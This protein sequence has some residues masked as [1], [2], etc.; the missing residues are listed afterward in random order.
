MS[1]NTAHEGYEYQDLLTAYFIL[2]EIL[3][4]HYAVFKIDTKEHSDDKFDD[5][6][7]TN[8]RIFKKQ[9][10]YS[11]EIS[12]HTTQKDD[13][14]NPHNY[15]LAIYDLFYSWKNLPS[16]PE[17][18]RLCLAW[19]E[20]T[21]KLT[22][23][24]IV[25]SKEKTFENYP[26]KLFQFDVNKLWPENNEPDNSWRKLRTESQNINRDEFVEFCSHLLIETN[27]P[28]QSFDKSFNGELEKII[29][30]LIDK[31]GI[32]EY[33]N[34][35]ITPKH[36]ALELLKLINRSRSRGFEISTEEIFDN[37]NILTDF[38]SI[39]QVFP[40]DKSK[41]IETKEI[42]TSFLEQIKNV[43]KIILKGE[44]GSG[45]SWFVQNL[46]NELSKQ[47]ISVVKHYCYTELRDIYA[48]K[49][50]TLNVF[51][52]NLINDIINTYPDLIN[53]KKK[54]YASNL[55]ELNELLRAIEEQ[56]IIIIDGLDHIER[57]F[58]SNQNDLTL[59]DVAIIDA[60]KKIEIND[61]TKILLV[62]QPINE[63][64]SLSDFHTVD[65][66]KW[67][68]K[69]IVEYLKKNEIE[70]IKLKENTLL[71]DFLLGKS[72]GNP[73]YL[74]YLIE[75]VKKIENINL[76]VLNKLPAYSYNLENYYE[77][78]IK[79]LNLD[80]TIPQ[81]LSG[82]QF[83][84][85][86]NELKEITGQGKLVDKSLI[87]LSPIL[88]QVYSNG[89]YII[90]HESFRR[91]IIEKL[92]KEEVNIIKAIYQPII[93]WFNKKDFFDFPK[94]YRYYF[95][96]LYE[97][98][99]FNE[100][101]SYLK[102]DF[103]IKSIYN[104][105][106]FEVIKNNFY[107]L[108]KAGLELKDFPK[109][110]LINEL[111]KVIISTEDEYFENF[112]LYF[113]ALGHLKG[114]KKISEYLVFDEKPTLPLHTGLE[115]CYLCSQNKEA[116]PW[117]IYLEYFE[118]NKEISIQDYKY[119]IRGLLVF[120]DSK[121]LIDNTIEVYE[122]Y[123]NYIFVFKK[124][125]L[126]YPDKDLINDLINQNNI[127]KKILN[128]KKEIT[129]NKDDL[130][131]LC[132]E[133]LKKENIFDD[134][135]PLLIDFFNLIEKNIEKNQLIEEVIKRFS[136]INWFYNW[137]I[138]YIK[139][140]LLS[141]NCSYLAVKEAFNY[142]IYDTEPFKNSHRTC[143][144]Y[145][146]KDFIYDSIKE[147]L[148]FV[149]TK[150]EWDEIINI[151]KKLSNETTTS[152]QKSINGPL[153]TDK[154]FQ[155]LDEYANEI[156]RE[157]IIQVFEE[158]ID[159]KETYY[160]HSYIT[161]FCFRLS[162][163]YSIYGD[164]NKAE[165]YF[166][167]GILFYLGYTFRKDRTLEDLIYAIESYSKLDYKKA[168]YDLKRI[169]SL[170]DA[171]VHHTD[172]KDT[173]WF[174][175][176]WFQKYLEINFDESSLYL[177]TQIKKRYY[178][179]YEEKLQDLLIKAN[180]KINPIVE[181]FIFLTFP[182]ETSEKFLLYGL[183]LVEKINNIDKSLAKI[184]FF[185]ITEKISLKK[186]QNFSEN[187]VEKFNKKLVEFNLKY[188]G[189]KT[190]KATQRNYNINRNRNRNRNRNLR[191]IL[192]EKY[193]SRKDFSEMNIQE[194]IEYFF[195]NKLNETE[196]IS[197]YYYFENINALIENDV[198]RLIETIVEKHEEYPKNRNIDLSLIFQKE[199]DISAYYWI[200]QFTTEQDGWFNKL[201]NIKAFEK[202][203]SINRELAINA[204]ATHLEKFLL[205]EGYNRGVSSN[206]INAFVK[207]GYHKETVIEMWNNLFEATGHRLPA[208]EVIN[209]EE[210][211]KDD[212]N[213]NIEEI[214]I[215]LL[216]TRFNSNTTE[217]HHWT[218]SGLYYLYEYFP[219]KMIKSTKWFLKN[220]KF[221][222]T[223]NLIIIL[224][225]LY[226]I[227]EQTYIQ[228]F[229]NELNEL[230]PSEYY[231]INYL[232]ESL[233][234]TN[235]PIVLKSNSLFFP[236]N[237]ESIDFFTG[238]NYRNELLNNIGFNFETIVG[239]N[240]NTFRKKYG[241][242]FEFLGNHSFEMYVKN[243]YSSN[244]VIELINK[245]LYK[246]LDDFPDKDSLYDLLKIDYKTIVSQTLSYAQ[247][248]N[249]IIRP[250]EIQNT[251][252]KL[253]IEENDWIRLGY[254]EYELYG[255]R[256]RKDEFRNYKIFEGIVFL[257]NLE[258]TIPFSRYRLFP[259]HLW[260]N[261]DINDFDEFLCVS[262]IQQ[263]DTLENFN[264]L[265]LN[266]FIM[267]ALNLKIGKPTEG[268]V[269]KYNKNEVV[270]KLNY[271]I[272][273]YVGDGELA[274]ITNEIPR[275][276]GVE[277]LCRKDYFNKI[278]EIY[279]PNESYRSY[280]YR[281]KI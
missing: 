128:Y 80:T 121:A 99:K 20:P 277:L 7:I 183:T 262:L 113:D 123:K 107:Y 16:K 253:E 278:C 170:V 256:F 78:L 202:A 245:E 200:T 204:L 71:S 97:I 265:W 172:G 90:Y 33:P 216:F 195:K 82:A 222:L 65:I 249:N 280:R 242:E 182:I 9:I 4:E 111:K 45:K 219:E 43:N 171:V 215:C 267:K 108:V 273:D 12:D 89:G 252:E 240:K 151:L 40:I 165:K 156:N 178:W 22:D 239:N 228:N 212:L 173:R 226:D 166:E 225:I 79:K 149:K 141:P 93:N 266:P 42:I 88:K 62:S 229:Y 57:I 145:S 281:L 217:R 122:N 157:K 83:S 32:G 116:A 67:S 218:L 25:S 73:L 230:Y 185:T 223:S 28:K 102:K 243:I 98:G 193:K 100:I 27:F 132:D 261:I 161:E 52:A 81:I 234:D 194:M 69:E 92:E 184:V 155:L 221:F 119:Y 18:I 227:D 164:K 44:P 96:I 72:N 246:E 46:Q 254:I 112:S 247:R 137:L 124:E 70:N 179:I 85:L 160:L 232:I 56:I 127:F 159:K 8:E 258:K 264:I 26:T 248:P 197:L 241:E 129:I 177:L 169:K 148:R 68:N 120:R 130:L 208:K 75:E 34:N 6:T 29:L 31:L 37:L 269:V 251:W 30:D 188:E 275:L 201:V 39:E 175:V 60:I 54:R 224:E 77:Y 14:S 199:N 279:K 163:Q 255:E 142:L 191:N 210:L 237:K 106:S 19:N 276:E 150:G 61:N 11:N 154:F 49:R 181:A 41:N 110:I 260:N 198:K 196:L 136:G 274:E 272:S 135:L 146:A 203:F 153:A 51:Y 15:D 94:A 48:K 158:L 23:F 250:S 103:I 174:P 133:L 176:E 63:L 244:Y 84:L 186:E 3:N 190:Q 64:K 74:N 35:H 17:E 238:I 214:F 236:A 109:I 86:K 38:G 233:I 207:I 5:L 104:G 2:Q 115:A 118:E 187:L 53:R 87:A 50:I 125:L 114:F 1:L 271:W 58:S 47:D 126:S 168:L 76:G 95:K 189:I 105:N 134:D 140:K 66:P 143:D 180:G 268:L 36:F 139:I 21:D 138:Y 231:L 220:S 13:F 117:E 257:D 167:K 162:K 206:L 91:F 259:V 205:P 10:K 131:L 235:N 270:L 144:L 55:E 263:Y 213:M 147:G 209:W 59:S 101:L 152:L 192:D 24:I 211:V